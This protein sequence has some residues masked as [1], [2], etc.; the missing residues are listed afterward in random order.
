MAERLETEVQ[1]K[2]RRRSKIVG[3]AMGAVEKPA[4]NDQEVAGLVSGK[5][6]GA[7]PGALEDGILPVAVICHPV[8]VGEN[9]LES[10][11]GGNGLGDAQERIL[12]QARAG[13]EET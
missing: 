1:I 12:G 8:L 5:D 7:I 10:R 11:L 4:V 6:K 2:H 9:K 3:E 13:L